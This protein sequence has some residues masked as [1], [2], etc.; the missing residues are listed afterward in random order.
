[1]R[2]SGELEQMRLT[3][4]GRAVR[5]TYLL[6]ILCCLVILQNKF[7]PS[8]SSVICLAHTALE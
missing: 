3:F 6:K 8:L 2:V 1:M 4:R 5:L 7:C